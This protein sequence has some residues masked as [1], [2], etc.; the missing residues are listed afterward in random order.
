MDNV[1]MGD[2]LY[3]KL[4]S[5]LD[6]ISALPVAGLG[7]L[8]VWDAVREVVEDISTAVDGDSSYGEWVLAP[9][10]D[11]K[12]VWD[13]LWAKPWGDFDI[14]SGDVLD[15]LAENDLIQEHEEDGDE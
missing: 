7:W 2:E 14:D 11:L 8:W 13:T 15:W 10:V 12:K 9:D 4:N 1:T 6:D 5:L 3:T